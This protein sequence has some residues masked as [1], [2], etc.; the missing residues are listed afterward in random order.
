[1]MCEGEREWMSIAEHS[2]TR[3]GTLVAGPH[4]NFRRAL[5][6]KLEAQLTKHASNEMK[7]QQNRQ[8]ATKNK[9]P[10]K[11]N[12]NTERVLHFL[13][14]WIRKL[15]WFHDDRFPKQLDFRVSYFS[16]RPTQNM[17]YLGVMFRHPP[18]ICQELFGSYLGVEDIFSTLLLS[19]KEDKFLWDVF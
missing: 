10:T 5:H 1:M 6:R 11:N 18:E 7:T 4:G 15:V 14:E 9:E 13:R 2:I 8:P 12:R 19:Q 17:S 16:K 3:V